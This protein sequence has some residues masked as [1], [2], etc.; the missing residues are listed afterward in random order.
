MTRRSLFSALLLVALL[1][2]TVKLASAALQQS[3]RSPALG[4]S[5]G[6][7]TSGSYA[8]RNVT[9][10]PMAGRTTSPSATVLVRDGRIAAVGPSSSV[11]VPNGVR[12]IDGTGKFLIPGLTDTHTHLLSDG[13]E[14]HDSAGPAELG[15]MVATGVT[16]ARLMIGT[17]EQL[18]LRA[19][20]AEGKVLGPQLW[21]ASPQ[22]TGRP[23][24]NALVVTTPDEARAAVKTASDAGY[25]F[26]KLTLF[27]DKPVHD[28]VTAEAQAR[29]IRVVGHVEPPVGLATAIA[30]NQ[31]LEHLDTFIEEAL[32]SGAPS[33]VSVTQG[34]VFQSAPWVTL[35]FVDN[36][37]LD[38]LAGVVARAGIYI[39][40]TQN[41]FNTAF[42]IGETRAQL[43]DRPDWAFWPPRMRQGYLN[44]HTRYWDPARAGEKTEARRRRYVEVRNR[45]VKAIQDSGGKLITGSDTPEWYHMYGWGLHRELQAL[46]K[47]GLTPHQALTASTVNAAAFLGASREWG[48]IETGKR[49]DLVLVTANPLDD[50]SNTLKI[51]A[52]SVGGRWLPRAELDAMI[53]A[54]SKLTGGFLQPTPPRSNDWLAMLPDGE[55]KRSFILDCTGCHQLDERMTRNGD[56]FRTREEWVASVTKMLGFAGATTGFPIISASRQ[57]EATAAFVSQHLNRMPSST[58]RAASPEVTEFPIS[59]PGDLPHD[60]AIDARGRVIV[61][62][63]FSHVLYALDPAS[64]KI[65]TLAIPVPNA[66]P[67]AVDIGP[68]GTW[69]VALG[70]PRSVV[71]YDPASKKWATHA[72]GYYPHSVAVDSSGG[73]WAN[74]HF[75]RDPELVSRVDPKSGQK[76]DFPLPKHP[77]LGDVA[78]GPIPY[79]IR[80]SPKGTVWLSELRG[81]RLLSVDPATKR[82][83]AH[84]MPATLSGPRRFDIDRNGTLWIP[85]YAYNALVKLDPATR[86]FQSFTMPV[87]DALPYVARINHTTGR[88]WLGTAAADAVYEFNPSTGAFQAY[89]LPTRGALVRH[90]AVNEKTGEVWVAYGESPGKAASR[91]ARIRPRGSN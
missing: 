18:Q 41:V 62:G 10:I 39:G 61:T 46:V 53:A 34:G 82:V 84:D 51:D 20:V 55:E 79:E 8:I 75:T 9:V 45:L 23:S 3:P 27:I 52:V 21:V 88:I 6:H 19:A 14:V 25:D 38:S 72:I 74:G 57:A 44:A 86:Q 31:Q 71:S 7:L 35:D 64:A 73:V 22:L 58:P 56:R 85:A 68:D 30:A 42:G 77:A 70:G 37:K 48:T 87:R 54:G 24:E 69:W 17:P 66:N 47:A 11:S 49:A 1:P 4:P 28:A 50:I 43:E 32:S 63:M 13:A 15:V 40:P 89:H 26:I 80:V 2:G 12:V 78:G 29:G 67:R 5:R 59:A 36:R 76:T 60:V 33:K 16:T 65:D 81:N 90:L 83:E 91:I